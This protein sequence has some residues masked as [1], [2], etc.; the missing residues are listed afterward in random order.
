MPKKP[1][2]AAPVAAWRAPD[3]RGIGHAF[4]RR[5]SAQA[6]CGLRTWDERHDW[7]VK[8]SCAGCVTAVNGGH[9]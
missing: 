7:P 1:A 3:A 8:S 2:A 6:Y 9:A 4:E 5:R